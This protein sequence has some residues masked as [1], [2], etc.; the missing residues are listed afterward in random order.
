MCHLLWTQKWCN[1][2]QP[3]TWFCDQNSSS[4]I[5]QFWLLFVL[6][7]PQSTGSHD[8]LTS[9]RLWPILLPK[10][11]EEKQFPLIMGEKQ[12]KVAQLLNADLWPWHTWLQL[13]FLTHPVFLH[14]RW[15][16]EAVWQTAPEI[17]AF[18]VNLVFQ[19][20]CWVRKGLESSTCVFG[21][22]RA[23]LQKE[24]CA[25]LWSCTS[26]LCVHIVLLCISG[27]R[28]SFWLFTWFWIWSQKDCS[29]KVRPLP[30][31]TQSKTLLSYDCDQNSWTGFWTQH[32][33][34]KASSVKHHAARLS[35]KITS[36][37]SAYLPPTR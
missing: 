25:T 15:Q 11:C 28:V 35:D 21:S 16:K 12:D 4:F 34:V 2:G 3:T 18:F 1:S 29:P 22:E 14:D 7:I 24:G 6:L 32:I 19:P 20:S 9:D 27:R 31:S 13:G 23:E 5:L 30:V 26:G 37:I 8:L 17:Q 33:W 36:V 10:C